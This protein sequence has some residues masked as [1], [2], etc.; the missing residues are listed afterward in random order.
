MIRYQESMQSYSIKTMARSIFMTLVNTL[1]K[2][3]INIIMNKAA[4]MGR[5]LISI[6]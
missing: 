3:I 4:L 6:W 5:E 2:I 1:F